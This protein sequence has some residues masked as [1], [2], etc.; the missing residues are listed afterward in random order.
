VS[1]HKKAAIR[2]TPLTYEEIVDRILETLRRAGALPQ[3]CA[4]TPWNAFVKLSNLIHDTYEVPATSFTPIMRRLL[5]ALGFGAQPRTVVGIG[6]YVGYTFS[7]LL[8]NRTDL[9]SAPFCDRAIGIDIDAAAN[10]IARR[11]CAAIKHG[12]RL[13]FLDGDGLRMIEKLKEPVDLLYLDLD[14]PITGKAGYR[15]VL[16]AATPL[17]SPGALV[18]AHDACVP[19]FAA[20][21]V[22]YHDYVQQCGLFSD[23]WILPVD[24]CGISVAA[25]QRA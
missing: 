9:E 2:S 16:E 12:R 4:P 23:M 18:L 22:A 7:W 14:D 21:F 10:K 1:T 17:L 13:M 5:F 6:T 24:S 8:R 15:S 3:V 20:S 25:V 11:N 19:K